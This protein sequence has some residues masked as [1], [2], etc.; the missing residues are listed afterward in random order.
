M[1]LAFFL[2]MTT[3]HARA[4]IRDMLTSADIQ[5]RLGKL[6]AGGSETVH[7]A[8]GY[9]IQLKALARPLRAPAE[10]V[11]QILWIR[12]GGGSFSVGS[13]A[14]RYEVGAGDLLRIESGAAYELQPKIERLEY[15]LVRISPLA[16]GAP[17]RSG[18]RPGQGKMGDLLSK[19]E[20][21]STIAAN[22]SNQPVHYS[23][24]FTINYVIYTGRAGPW[25]AHQGCADVYL[26]QTGSATAQLG[27]EILNVRTDSPG[28][29]R[30]TGVKGSRDYPI[31]A[32]DLVLIPRGVAHH[33]NP[34][35]GKLAYLLIK[36]W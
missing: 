34:G 27:G 6:A 12:R 14:R 28:E 23:D 7:S 18:I 30:G 11:D 10:S 8:P 26:L 21:D 35:A 9:S 25:E 24:N 15:L 19:K 32:G 31:A 4:E 5:A 36:L 17:A 16:P 29:P 20:I 2:L 22:T 1:R 3:I 33:M 13:P